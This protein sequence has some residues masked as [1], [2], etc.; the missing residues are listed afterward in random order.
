M[1]DKY[2]EACKR[3]VI[4][5]LPEYEGQIVEACELGLMLTESE[6]ANGSWYYS[7][8]RA[9]EDLDA[10]G[11]D[12]VAGFIEEYQSNYGDKPKYDA[13]CEPEGFHCLMMIVGVENVVNELAVIQKNWN[14]KLELTKPVIESMI[15][16]LEG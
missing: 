3:Y 14:K 2:I 13:Y 5:N 4:D 1:T 7:T 12:V 15:E 16:E 8:A 6:N 10:F 9:E 11:R